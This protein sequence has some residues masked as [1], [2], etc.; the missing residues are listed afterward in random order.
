MK[1]SFQMLLISL[2]ACSM[3]SNATRAQQYNESSDFSYA[4]KL[5]NEAFYDIAAQQFASFINRYTSSER[6]ADAR[7]Y[8]GD[9]LFRIGEI[10]NA[11][12]E[13]QAL[14]VGSPDH[15]RAPQAWIKVGDCYQALNKYEEAAKAYETVKI[16]YQSNALAPNGLL[17]AS[18]MY[19]KVNQLARAEQ[20][21]K[22]FLDRYPE[23]S[24]YPRGRILYGK[25][26]LGKGEFER[27]GNEFQQVA[28]MT[29]DKTFQAKARLGEASVYQQLGLTN[30]ALET[31][32]KIL[33][34]QSGGEL[35]FQALDAMTE[36]Y[37]QERR[38]EEAK[39]VLK[40]ESVKYTTSEQ[41]NQTKLLLAKTSFLQGD[42]FVARRS[43][44]EIK[45]FDQNSELSATV[46]FYLACCLMEENKLP[47]AAKQ[48]EAVL[49]SGSDSPA[50]QEFRRAS[51]YNLTRLNIRSGD[52]ASAKTYL[53]QFEVESPGDPNTENL[54]QSMVELA[55]RKNLLSAGVDELQRFKGAY[56]ASLVRDD[57]IYEAGKAFFRDRQ[58]DRSLI[59]FEQIVDQYPSSAKWDSSKTY[60]DF[61]NTYY[62]RGQETGVSDLAKLMGKMLSGVDHNELM[63]EL[64][65]IYLSEL[66]DY[67]EAA[68][69]FEKYVSVSRGDSSAAGAGYYYLSE[70]YIRLAEYHKIFNTSKTRYEEK[71]LETLK[72]AIQYVKVAPRPDTLTYRFLM[73]TAPL[74]TTPEDKLVRFWGHFADNYSKSDL[75]PGVQLGL[76]GAL[77]KNG[78]TPEALQYLDAVMANRKNA[79]AAGKAYWQKAE[80]MASQG[81]W[82]GASQLLK[83]FLL[84]FP[85]HPYQA[86]GHWKLAEYYA[87]S[88][89]YATAAQ[90]LER[91]LE[92]YN[93]SDYAENA[94][95]K[96]SDYYINNA[97][98]AKSLKFVEPQI[99]QFYPYNDLVVRHYLSNSPGDIF[100]YA[101][102]AYFEQKN[103]QL[104]R[105]NLLQYLNA[106]QH[107]D[108]QSEALLLLGKMA[109]T[110]GDEESALL[111]YALIK[112]D[113]NA[114]AYAIATDAAAEILFRQAKYDEAKSK[115]DLLIA[116]TL[117]PDQKM[118]YEAQ[119]IRCLINLGSN[120]SAQSQLAAFKKTYSSQGD[121]KEY[122]AA[123]EYEYAKTAIGNK[124]FD[125]SIKHCKTILSKYKSTAYAD[126]AQ[127][128]L[129]MNY[130]TLNRSEEALKQ[131]DKFFAN[132][133]NS[134]ITANAYL[135]VAQIHFRSE[136][137]DLGLEAIRSAVAASRTSSDPKTEQTA[138]ASLIATYKKVGL[139]DGVLQN[140]REYVR[141]FPNADDI[142]DQK[143]QVGIALIRMNRYLEA[144]DY[145]KTLKFEISSEQEPEIQYYIGEAYYNAGQYENAIRE[146]VKIP[147]LSQKTKLQWEATA[148]YYAGQSYEKLGRSD[149][150]VRMYQ[151]ILDRPGIQIELKREA[152]KLIDNL[153]SF[154]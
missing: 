94:P 61:T 143:V 3:M 101:G 24:E 92:R 18:E 131:F 36:I 67:E 54:H 48:F 118:K 38:W 104:A 93:Y 128:L 30:R 46:A 26:L 83:D 98:Y 86:R 14:A 47:E 72:E 91:M 122:L 111:H 99:A 53:G 17:L 1:K 58:Y 152:R 88:G 108:L 107:S 124:S 106:S 76:A 5:Y 13:F 68:N 41:T 130:A 102:K 79:Y 23:S 70:S 11:R 95:Q 22:E 25:I 110:E 21:A 33:V 65:R 16:L 55:F 148:L 2:L 136:K 43:L 90:F 129:G 52:L 42:Y 125:R 74:E 105:Q 77:Q 69:I 80:I 59:F 28:D 29:D 139:W 145:M 44:E 73:A 12:I 141:K 20:I 103:H 123:I 142:G 149:D 121:Q 151:E 127:Y 85:N 150:A 37:L 135:A 34:L 120:Q 138:L 4:L 7:Y 57:L 154:N 117:E 51:L 78:N 6:Q 96:I 97:D 113:D 140:A 10:D 147:L 112:P 87:E 40:R 144:I 84:E 153:N 132:Y 50:I 8:L 66:K 75:L 49:N 109:E 56:P 32:E 60:I 133:P 62:T 89:D 15:S 126:N 100:F 35:G 115:Y 31:L 64:G 114:A 146:F 63:F 39:T 119:K 82:A 9:A 81:N 71:S 134:D 19:M 45:I 116:G 137:T 27:A